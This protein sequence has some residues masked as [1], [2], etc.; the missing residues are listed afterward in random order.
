[1]DFGV[2]FWF[3]GRT[4]WGTRQLR[5]CTFWKYSHAIYIAL[6]CVA[7]PYKPLASLF[8]P[9]NFTLDKLLPHTHYLY[10]SSLLSIQGYELKG[11][12]ASTMAHVRE[13]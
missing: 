12:G 5:S 3:C 1:M 10:F 7:L 11:N 13:E 9:Q 6:I 4:V 8:V 2:V